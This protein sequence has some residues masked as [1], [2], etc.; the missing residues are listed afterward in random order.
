M[1]EQITLQDDEVVIKKETR[2]TLLEAGKEVFELRNKVNAQEKILQEQTN[3][4]A[5][6]K[7]N[8]ELITYCVIGFT[9]TFGLNNEDGTMIRESIMSGEESVLRSVM[10][11]MGS[12]MTDGMLAETNKAK[13]EQ[14]EQ[15]FSFLNYL[16]PVADFYTAQKQIKLN[17]NRESIK[18]LPVMVQK[19]LMNE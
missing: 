12:L 18:T 14:M 1:P 6:Y 4:L 2:T 8:F 16:K 3:I 19:S 10:K 9:G 7:L 15:K 13:K 11:N 17:F 5:S